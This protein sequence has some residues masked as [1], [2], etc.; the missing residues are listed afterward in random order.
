MAVIIWEQKEPIDGIVGLSRGNGFFN[1]SAAL[2]QEP[3]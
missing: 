2:E 1:Q 3:G